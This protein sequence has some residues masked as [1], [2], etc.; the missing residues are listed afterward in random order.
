[1]IRKFQRTAKEKFQFTPGVIKVMLG[2]K[3]KVKY[4]GKEFVGILEDFYYDGKHNS[5]LII[6][7]ELG[8][9]KHIKLYRLEKIEIV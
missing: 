5:G 7:S 4:D 8:E 2:E 9:W 3:L 1:M 6:E